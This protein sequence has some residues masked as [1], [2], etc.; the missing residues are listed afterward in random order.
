MNDHTVSAPGFKLM[1]VWTAVGITS[2]ADAASMAQF[3][4]GTLA[5]VYTAILIGEWAIK[6]QKA[7][8]K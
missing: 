3:F 4:A 1:S 6:K 7:R 5:A 8:K 2:W